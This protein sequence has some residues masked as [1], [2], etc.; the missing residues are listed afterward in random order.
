M[1]LSAAT[2]VLAAGGTLRQGDRAPRDAGDAN[3]VARIGQLLPRTGTVVAD[4]AGL[5]VSADDE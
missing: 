2:R 5:E 3:N 1:S 4:E